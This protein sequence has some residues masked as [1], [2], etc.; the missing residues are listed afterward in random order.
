MLEWLLILFL[1]LHLVI[2]VLFYFG[3]R[4]VFQNCSQSLLRYFRYFGVAF[5]GVGIVGYVLATF[6]QLIGIVLWLLG[7][8]VLSCI[9]TYYLYLQITR[10]LS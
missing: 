8:M 2:G 6:L 10:K 1:G 9:F 7:S 3:A 5:F 4:G